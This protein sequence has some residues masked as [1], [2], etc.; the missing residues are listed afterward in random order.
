MIFFDS[1]GSNIEDVAREAGSIDLETSL[2]QGM[3]WFG[4]SFKFY[5]TTSETLLETCDA[6]PPVFCR[7]A[8]GVGA[9]GYVRRNSW[10]ILPAARNGAGRYLKP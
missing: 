7:P 9:A 4:F 2:L 10:H 1:F 6:S 5:F 8:I 3:T